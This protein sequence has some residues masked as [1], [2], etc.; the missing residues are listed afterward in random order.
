M[1]NFLAARICEK[2]NAP[3]DPQKAKEVLN[4]IDEWFS[5]AA[6]GLNEDE[7]EQLPTPWLFDDGIWDL[8][9][10]LGEN[11][12]DT[13]IDNCLGMV[14]DLFT[15]LVSIAREAHGIELAFSV[16]SLDPKGVQRPDPFWGAKYPAMKTVMEKIINCV[17]KKL[18]RVIQEGTIA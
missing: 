1:Q 9:G 3:Q 6:L 18:K 11:Q 17:Q 2:Y 12:T 13:C 16:P 5:K 14:H 4:F 15:K 10:R 8:L 7:I